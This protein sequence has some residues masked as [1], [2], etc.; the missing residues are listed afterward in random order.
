MQRA[1]MSIPPS[2]TPVQYRC[3]GELRAPRVCVHAILN[4]RYLFSMYSQSCLAT[5]FPPG[6][7]EERGAMSTWPL[8]KSVGYFDVPVTSMGA[9]KLLEISPRA[10][11]VMIEWP[12]HV[13][14]AH[15]GEN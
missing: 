7:K 10:F 3:W 8:R 14:T 12:R 1:P 2:R 9:L 15:R 11:P 13:P 5:A 4:S 6:P